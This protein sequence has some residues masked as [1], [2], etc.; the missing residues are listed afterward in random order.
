MKSLN[1][2]EMMKSVASRGIAN[3]IRREND[4][5]DDEGLLV[6]GICGERRQN[7]MIFPNPSEEDPKRES[8]L[9]V[10][11]MCRCD[12][13]QDE[14]EKRREQAKKNM[15]L[16]ETLKKASLMDE[17]FKDA[18][19]SAFKL[20]K[21]NRRNLKLCKRYADKFD[22]MMEKNQGLLFWGDVGTGKTFAAACIANELL[23]K[24]HPV[25]LTSFVRLLEIIQRGGD[26]DLAT[27]RRINRADL[28]IFDDLGA[29]RGTEYALEKVYGIVDDRYRRKL[30]SIFTTNLT[31]S[32]MESETD[33]RY[34]RIYDR[35]FESC[36]PM[37]FTGPSWRK[38]EAGRRFEEMRH[39]LEE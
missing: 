37:Q 6:C 25:I 26:E 13:E 14:L 27:L 23:D 10:S 29:E 18:R 16:V 4:Y 8:P 20:N 33:P 39:I 5:I 11:R 38:K 2:Y 12:R 34:S 15:E 1:P 36:Y 9:T 31:L 19:F 35:I 7:V 28:V 17:R 22:L 21:D 24:M 3:Q 32:E 30:P